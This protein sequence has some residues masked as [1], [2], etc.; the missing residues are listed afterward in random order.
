MKKQ[1]QFVVRG[2]KYETRTEDSGSKVIRGLI[3]YNSKSEDLGFYEIISSTAFNK[4]L[5]DGVDVKALQDH[6]TSKVIGSTRAKTLILESTPAGLVCECTLPKTTYAEDL[7]EVISRGD[8]D[9][10]SFG[11]SPVKY[12]DQ[13]NTRTLKEVKLHEISFGVP[14]PA[15]AE[16]TSMVF[17]RSWFQKRGLEL[18]KLSSVLEKAEDNKAITKEDEEILKNVVSS[19]EKLYIKEEQETI[20]TESTTEPAAAT[21]TENQLFS[22]LAETE[23]LLGEI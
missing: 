11:F 22:F 13:G 9:T 1:N 20:I 10:M 23:L 6:D 15:Y 17:T 18:D 14:F 2:I 21:Q 3:P 7:Y 16:T 4:T 12:E 5:A 8:V 19:L